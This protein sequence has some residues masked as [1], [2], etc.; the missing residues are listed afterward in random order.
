MASETASRRPL[1]RA[2]GSAPRALS[3]P[4]GPRGDR[5]RPERRL[6]GQNAHVRRVVG[7]HGTT[8]ATA[9]GRL[10]PCHL[11]HVYVDAD[12]VCAAYGPRTR[13][14]CCWIGCEAVA[15]TFFELLAWPPGWRHVVCA[16]GVD[17]MV[18]CMQ[19]SRDI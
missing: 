4:N 19:K 6:R 9:R 8:L 7:L 3:R 5:W 1:A 14:W 16:D 17:E 18:V 2:P 10:P 11:H 13:A 12:R 15:T